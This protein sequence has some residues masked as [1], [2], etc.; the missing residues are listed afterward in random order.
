METINRV[1]LQ[2]TVGNVRI[3]EA[4]ERKVLH[5]S[6]VTN[7]VGR[8]RE[9]EN[10]VEASWH[11]VEAWEGPNIADFSKIVKGCGVHLSGRLRYS[12][13]TGNDKV[14]RTAVDIVA[15]R[16]ELVEDSVA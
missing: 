9:G 8:N 5:I 14:E 10:F 1:E 3:Q 7:R 6:V 4:G 13:Y 11:N 12:K 15:S 16:L 2:G